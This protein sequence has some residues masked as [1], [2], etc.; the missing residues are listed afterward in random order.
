MNSARYKISLRITHPSIKSDE[1]TREIGLQPDIF[2]SV[3]DQKKTPVGTQ[4]HAVRKESF[5]CC[6]LPESGDSLEEAIQSFTDSLEVRKIFFQRL[7]STGGRIEYFIGWFCAGNSGFVM[8]CDISKKLSDLQI[9]LA[10]D[11]YVDDFR[12]GEEGGGV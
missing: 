8:D 11:I 3:G 2:Y 6:N 5:W 12:G 9:N 4:L 10:F 7:T 1:I